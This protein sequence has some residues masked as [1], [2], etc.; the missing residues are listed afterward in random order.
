[1][2]S[3]FS[4][5]TWTRV[6]P[7]KS[8]PRFAEPRWI[9]MNGRTMPA[10]L[11]ASSM[12]FS[13]GQ[14]E[15]DVLVIETTKLTAGTLDGSLLPMSGEDTRIVERWAFSEDRLT[16]DHTMTIYDPFYDKP[17]VRQRGS[18]RRDS[19]EVFEPAP[20]DPDGFFRDL[21]ETERLKQ[22]LDQ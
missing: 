13:L 6:P 18:A 3:D 19:L 10:G 4:N 16:M 12:G 2:G 21:V 17:L 11:P 8:I 22:H 7:E 5:F 1:M 9:W 14:W 20:C 15:D